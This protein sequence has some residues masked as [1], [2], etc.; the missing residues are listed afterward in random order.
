MYIDDSTGC[1]VRVSSEIFDPWSLTRDLTSYF[2][3]K[4]F[5]TLRG[6]DFGAARPF[7]HYLT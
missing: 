5:Y 4:Q 1:F 6:R 3:R 2:S 7:S